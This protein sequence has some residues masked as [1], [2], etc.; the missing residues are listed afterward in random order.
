MNA[1]V[2]HVLGKPPRFEQFAEP[3]AG[4]GE[5]IVHVHCAS[6]KTHRQTVGQRFTLYQ[7][8]PTSVGLRYRRRW[9]PE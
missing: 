4:D 3:V 9:T 5:D 1:A 7:A 2:L 6:L 8:A